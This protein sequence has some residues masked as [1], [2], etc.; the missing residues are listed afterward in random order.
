MFNLTSV[1]VWTMI[2]FIIALVCGWICGSVM[3]YQKQY[4]Y[5]KALEEKLQ[6]VKNNKHFIGR[7][8]Y[9]QRW[10]D[11]WQQVGKLVYDAWKGEK[12]EKDIYTIEMDQK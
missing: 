1:F 11:E 12:K 2:I 6:Q 3:E 8:Y 7:K 10:G 9:I 4:S 5:I